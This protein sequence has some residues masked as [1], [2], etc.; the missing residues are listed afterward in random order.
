MVRNYRWR[1]VHAVRYWIHSPGLLAICIFICTAA[2][3]YFIGP[4]LWLIP[5]WFFA[6][7]MVGEAL[8]G[9]RRPNSLALMV[10][11]GLLIGAC[12]AFAFVYLVT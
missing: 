3:C 8:F 12:L 9:P 2:W 4:S 5:I 7:A 1:H 10:L 6:A 11:T